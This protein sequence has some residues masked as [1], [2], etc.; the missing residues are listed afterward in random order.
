MAGEPLADECPVRSRVIGREADVLALEQHRAWLARRTPRRPDGP[1]PARR[2]WAAVELPVARPITASGRSF[3]TRTI[4]SATS[5][6]ASSADGVMTT[7]NLRS[8]RPAHRRRSSPSRRGTAR[9]G[10]RQHAYPRPRPSSTGEVEEVGGSRRRW[11]SP[12]RQ[13][14]VNWTRPDC[15]V[16]QGSCCWARTPSAVRTL[17]RDLDAADPPA[18]PRSRPSTS[19]AS[20]TR[21]APS[22]PGA[23]ATPS[24]RRPGRR[25]CRHRSTPATTVPSASVAP[26]GP[27][28]RWLNGRIAEQVRDVRRAGGEFR[29]EPRL[30]DAPVWPS[31]TT[32][33]RPVSSSTTAMLP[34]SSG[35]TVASTTP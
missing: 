34:G 21:S 5:R 8:S 2:M 4:T 10:S 20:V 17:R 1:R 26:I 18:P 19:T 22:W 30:A 24:G 31:E 14:P 16:E 27:G 32:T 12:Q 6:P 13:Q 7:P 15:L 29:G 25:G 11:R 23:P 3:S 35:A 28:S 9:G 33:P